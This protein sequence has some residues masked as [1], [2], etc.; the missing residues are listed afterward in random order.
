MRNR[1]ID[2]R[3]IAAFAALVRHKSFTLAAKDLFLTQS[4]VSHA[5]KT[6][7]AEIGC[8]LFERFGRTVTLTRAGERFHQRT[9]AILSEMRAAR[10]EIENLSS[11]SHGQL[12]VG[13][14]TLVCQYILPRVLREFQESHPKCSVR[15][16]SGSR[17]HRLELLRTHQIDFDIT[18]E[19]PAAEHLEFEPLFEDELIFFAAAHHPWAGL[20]RVPR[21]AATSATFVI[22]G[23]GRQTL[24]LLADYFRTEKISPQTLVNPGSIDAARELVKAGFGIGL[25]A[26]WQVATELAKGTLVAV[27]FSS[28][29]LERRWV[30]ARLK[31]SQPGAVER[32]F[33][34][35]CKAAWESL[36]ATAARP[37][38]APA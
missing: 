22:P 35:R 19:G 7:E 37:V 31:G 36:G 8:R 10:V 18:I 6:L 12:C 23:K 9:E 5:I 16:E 17:A 3:Q 30:V 26:P 33:I 32:E 25:F 34:R 24:R 13:A 11:T 1:V 15:L 27:R 14:G 29:S 28:R 21:N 4:A 38:L 20:S 2:S